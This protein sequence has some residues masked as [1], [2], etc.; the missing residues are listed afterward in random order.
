MCVFINLLTRFFETDPYVVI[1]VE[2]ASTSLCSQGWPCTPDS[3]A[4]TSLTVET[5]KCTNMSVSL[6][7]A[8]DTQ[9]VMSCYM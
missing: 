5:D 7:G 3:P 2:L 9:A 6:A 1:E 8:G 4:S